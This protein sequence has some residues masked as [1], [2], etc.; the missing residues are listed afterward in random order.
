MFAPKDLFDLTK[1]DFAAIFEGAGY[2]WEIL[3]KIKDFILKTGPALGPDYA[4]IMPGVWVGS[5]TT[6]AK[7]VL[8]EGP[9]II[10]K[11]TEIRQCAFIRANAVIG[12]NCVI[13][14]SCEIKNSFIFDKAQIPH[15]NYVGDSILG[16]K[17]HIGAGVICSN[18]KSIPGNVKVKHGSQIID[19]G[20]RK[21]SAVLGD[22]VEVGCNSVLNPGT[23]VGKG[24]VVYPLSS[25]RGYIPP[26]HIFKGHGQPPVKKDL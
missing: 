10:G 9:A 23:V 24:S 7:T 12:N 14:N 21:F 25:V 11:N 16:C 3:P 18:V 17:S 2:A 4:E 13:G 8:I 26:Q 19:T 20:L 6:I 5:G 22:N 15:F 1:T